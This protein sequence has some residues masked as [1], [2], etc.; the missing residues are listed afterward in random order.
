M[1]RANMAV[2]DLETG[3][4]TPLADWLRE[5]RRQQLALILAQL[6]RGDGGGKRPLPDQL[7]QALFAPLEPTG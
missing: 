7:A 2:I 3:E 5:Q 6:E 1:F 4:L